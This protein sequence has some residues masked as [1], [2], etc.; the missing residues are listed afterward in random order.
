MAKRMSAK[1]YRMSFADR[2]SMKP[3]ESQLETL[4]AEVTYNSEWLAEAKAEA[5]TR[6]MRLASKR[7]REAQSMLKQIG[8][9]AA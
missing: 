9:E 6:G 8:Q 7:L 1:Y 5:N 3:L 4:R 2:V